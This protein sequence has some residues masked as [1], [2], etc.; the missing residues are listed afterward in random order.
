MRYFCDICNNCLII[1]PGDNLF[2]YNINCSKEHQKKNVSLI[3]ILS[4]KNLNEK[5][6][7]CENHNKPLK[8]YC[9]IC[10]KEI[11]N[12]CLHTVHVGHKFELLNFLKKEAINNV[13][14]QIFKKIIDNFFY[15]LDILEKKTNQKMKQ[16]KELKNIMIF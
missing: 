5:I 1:S 13:L 8:I 6:F 7:Q 4:K 12:D 10:K 15:E 11:C 3:D 16:I 2:T 9:Y 14:V